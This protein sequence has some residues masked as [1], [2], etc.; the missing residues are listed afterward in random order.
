[1]MISIVDNE[2]KSIVAIVES[3]TGE[4][5][6]KVESGEYFEVA[7]PPDLIGKAI[8]FEDGQIFELD[9][10]LSHYAIINP[11]SNKIIR[12]A[13]GRVAGSFRKQIDEGSLIERVI[14]N[15]L[16]NKIIK[17][18]PETGMVVQDID[19]TQSENE[20]SKRKK[21]AK[22]ALTEFMTEENPNLKQTQDAVKAIITTI[23][24]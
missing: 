23:V 17:Y 13:F 21:D 24:E 5:K 20:R 22:D 12:Q 8:K 6:D 16:I 18:D 10:S 1:M 19:A 11:A 14:P 4:I 3:S 7:I 9:D 2:T 15:D